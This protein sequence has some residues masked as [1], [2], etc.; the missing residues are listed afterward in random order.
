MSDY[1]CEFCKNGT[2]ITDG[3]E[4][5]RHI[6]C[7]THPNL[8]MCDTCGRHASEM[9]SRKLDKIIMVQHLDIPPI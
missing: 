4:R 8:W 5:M 7:G 3:T 1:S 2:Y 6:G 9:R